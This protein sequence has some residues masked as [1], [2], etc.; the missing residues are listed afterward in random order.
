MGSLIDKFGR[1][2]SYLRLS[3]TDR[4]D[5][6]CAYCM[7]ERMVFLPKL[8]LLTLEE[9]SKLSH[10]FIDK[11]IRKIRI[12]GGEPLLRRDIL[13]LF[14]DISPRLKSD[15]SE[16][17][18][19]TNATQLSKY[20][21]H[22]ARIGVKRINVSLDSLD[23]GIFAKLSR[24]NALKSVLEGIQA[25]KEAG[26]KIKINT[27]LLP[28]NLAEVPNIMSWAHD[29]EFDMSLIEIMPMGQTGEDRRRQFVPMQAAHTLL[30]GKYNLTSIIT[31]DK[32]GGPARY[33]HVSETNGRIGFISPLTQNFC[34][35]CN[36]IRMTC[37]G[38]I[39]MCLGQEDYIDLR[40]ILRSGESLDGAIYIALQN[41]PK[42]HDFLITKEPSLSRHMSVT[43]G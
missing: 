25:A 2:V 10:Y 41:K 11:G 40:Q 3:V 22:L 30:E 15:L 39:Y 4:C 1:H 38:R 31:N 35:G 17:T 27:V 32:L 18:L 7:S 43:G 9:L 19:T 37:T 16:L 20:A 36:R 21:D 6:R 23:E 33:Y 24:R 26:I 8:D 5:L 29:Q 13:S 34:A 42:A 28:E 12:S 14:E